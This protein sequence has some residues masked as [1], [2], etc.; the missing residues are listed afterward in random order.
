MLDSN[1]GVIETH[2]VAAHNGRWDKLVDRAV[3]VDAEVRTDIGTLPKLDI[4]PI[5]REGVVDRLDAVG[6][7][8]MLHD[9]PRVL[10]F[11]RVHP[12]MALCVCRH[13]RFS[14]Q[15]KRNE[16][17]HQGRL[18]RGRATAGPG[19]TGR[20]WA[21]PSGSASLTTAGSTTP[22]GHRHGRSQKQRAPWWPAGSTGTGSFMHD[23]LS[24]TP[25]PDGTQPLTNPFQ[26]PLEAPQGRTLFS[27]R[28][29]LRERG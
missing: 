22:R 21:Y 20:C 27:W 29:R 14:V 25:K 17:T 24:L 23:Y 4:R 2:D 13:F 3:A 1:R 11:V 5:A 18:F 15:R 28:T 26:A 12:I 6:L 16:H 8:D 7:R 9:G 10:Q 19:R